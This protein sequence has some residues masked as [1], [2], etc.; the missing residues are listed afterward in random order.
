MWCVPLHLIP[1]FILGFSHIIHKPHHTQVKDFAYVL[2]CWWSINNHRHHPL[3]FW[4]HHKWK[5]HWPRWCPHTHGIILILEQRQR[6]SEI[7]NY[8]H[9]LSTPDPGQIYSFNLT[10]PFLCICH[11]LRAVVKY[12]SLSEANVSQR[13]TSS[14][15]RPTFKGLF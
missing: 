6:N 13:R 8:L 3:W 10:N 5:W 15:G 11:P 4:R 12:S 2:V 1:L 14:S 7:I 9:F